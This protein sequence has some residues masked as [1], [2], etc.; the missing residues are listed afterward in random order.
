MGQRGIARF[1]PVQDM[2]RTMAYEGE[3]LHACGL[4]E[5]DFSKTWIV[6]V[7]GDGPNLCGHLLV[8]AA[9]N[10]G[11]YFHVTGDPTASGIMKVRGYPMYMDDAGYRRYLVETV[12]TELR[13]RMVKLPNPAGSALYV[14]SLLSEKW[15][16]AVLPHNC[17]D[18]VEEVIKAGGG[19]WT[20]YSN[21]P[22]ISISDDIPT[23]IQTFFNS[24]E[25]MLEGEIYRIYGVPRF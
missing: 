4:I 13:R 15:T 20:S 9:S 25:N 19:G 8:Y 2:E 1:F 11:Y 23:K 3:I 12:K 17:V 14:E 24:M 18:F 7:S 6:A 21:C 5:L 10:P 22:V 16:W